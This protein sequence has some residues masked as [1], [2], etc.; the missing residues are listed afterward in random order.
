M[1]ATEDI[2]LGG[3]LFYVIPQCRNKNEQTLTPSV[4]SVNKLCSV[5]VLCL[6]C[7]YTYI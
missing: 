4:L 2:G 6:K 5:V 7:M 3:L 1:S